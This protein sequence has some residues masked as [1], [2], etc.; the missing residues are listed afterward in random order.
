MQKM[1]ESAVYYCELFIKGA[2]VPR[3]LTKS[4]KI[5]EIYVKEKDKSQYLLL[6]GKINKK[7]RKYE[8]AIH[9][10]KES[11]LLEN[12]ESMYEYGRI[13]YKGKKSLF[14]NKQEAVK[15]FE[16]AIEKGCSKAM[17]EYGMIL[18]QCNIKIDQ[19]KC[20]KYIKMAAEK[21]NQDACYVYSLMLFNGDGVPKN[22]DAFNQYLNS[23]F[24]KLYKIIQ[25]WIKNHAKFA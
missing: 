14:I 7:E 10:F 4:K 8:D 3:N 11:I 13:L 22:I 25:D 1:I 19:E 2:I 23:E 17:L 9:C 24:N 18:K 16:K 6:L 20:I 5:I 21:G 12:A 15:Y